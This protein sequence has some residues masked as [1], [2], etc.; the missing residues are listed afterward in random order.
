MGGGCPPPRRFGLCVCASAVG[1]SSSREG[2]LLGWECAHVCLKLAICVACCNLEYFGCSAGISCREQR[3]AV[4]RCLML[5]LMFGDW[6]S[7]CCACI[8]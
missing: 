4:G 8:K 6:A 2:R 3:L 7:A 5:V 1:V